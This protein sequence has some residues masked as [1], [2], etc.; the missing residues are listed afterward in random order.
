MNNDIILDTDM[1]L[2]DL[3]D[4]MVSVS[5]DYSVTIH[6]AE[7]GSDPLYSQKLRMAKRMKASLKEL[8]VSLIKKHDTVDKSEEQ[9][10]RM[11]FLNI[12]A[13]KLLLEHGIAQWQ[14]A[15]NDETM[16]K[17]FAAHHIVPPM[18][19]WQAEWEDFYQYCCDTYTNRMQRYEEERIRNQKLEHLINIRETRLRAF[20]GTIDFHPGVSATVSSHFCPIKRN[21]KFS[22][23]LFNVRLHFNDQC[24]K[25]P[26]RLHQA[27]ACT[28]RIVETIRKIN[29]LIPALQQAVKDDKREHNR[30]LRVVSS[31][32]HRYE[33]YG[34]LPNSLFVVDTSAVV[35]RVDDKQ[36]A[37]CRIVGNIN[38]LVNSL[39]LFI[40]QQK[41]D[42][43][44]KRKWFM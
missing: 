2:D 4:I 10:F 22:W 23:G 6:R 24:L 16:L 14:N 15:P 11:R 19:E 5:T 18:A 44:T 32:Y 34:V 9:Y 41:V 40:I 28:N 27:D 12:M 39:H 21:G 25:F 36:L 35:G 7:P 37:T 8:R 20:I 29:D 26:L 1:W 3:P 31:V 42:D 38:K 17:Q 30:T 13:L 33:D 43:E